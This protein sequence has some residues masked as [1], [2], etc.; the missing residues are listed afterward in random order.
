MNPSLKHADPSE[1][2]IIDT[3]RCWEPLSKLDSRVSFHVLLDLPSEFELP[4]DMTRYVHV[5]KVPQTFEAQHATYKARALE[6]FRK[7]CKFLENDWV[8][9]L[10]EETR[11]DQYALNACIDFIEKGS[12]H[13][14]LPFPPFKTNPASLVLN[15]LPSSI[16]KQHD[17]PSIELRVQEPVPVTYEA[18]QSLP[19]KLFGGLDDRTAR[20]DFVI[21]IGMAAQR[22]FSI[23]QQ[24]RRDGYFRPDADRVTLK[25]G[26]VRTWVDEG[27]P[28]MLTSK[29][30]VQFVAK[31]VAESLNHSEGGTKSFDVR[32]S[33]DAGLYLCEFIYY[34]SLRWWWLDGSPDHAPGIVFLHIPA[35]VKEADIDRAAK[36]VQELAIALV[37]YAS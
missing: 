14:G 25:D 12:E 9:H 3:A 4:K 23:E 24:A 18:T 32:K 31:K 13:L 6:W 2:T 17:W 1:K 11:I 20:P 15:L 26:V 36:V 22:H 29:V 7:S 10:D 35:E 33:E 8:L 19:T 27:D 30:D 28:E 37:Q 16:K 5:D 21:H 34:C